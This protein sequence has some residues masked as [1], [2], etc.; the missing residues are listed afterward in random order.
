MKKFIS[1]FLISAFTLPLMAQEV[2]KEEV[3]EESTRC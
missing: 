2:E 1:C 3:K